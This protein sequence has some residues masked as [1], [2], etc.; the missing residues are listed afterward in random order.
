MEENFFAVLMHILSKLAFF[1][2]PVVNTN[3]QLLKP[4][5]LLLN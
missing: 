4:V 3:N 5:I 1:Y 2:L